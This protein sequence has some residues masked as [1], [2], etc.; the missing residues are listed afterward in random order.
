MPRKPVT[1]QPGSA[2]EP[3][4]QVDTE[5]NVDK[6][7][8]AGRSGGTHKVAK[9][10]PVVPPS[11]VQ[12]DPERPATAAVNAKKEMS[13]AEAMKLLAAGELKRSVLTDQG[14]VCVAKAVPGIAKT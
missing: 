12:G 5:S 8:E 1:R 6:A 10:K 13:Y 14:W 4:E 7:I 11:K 3:T 2:P 9:P